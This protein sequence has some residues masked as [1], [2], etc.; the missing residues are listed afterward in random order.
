MNKSKE[1]KPYGHNDLGKKEEVALM[2]DNISHHYDFLNHLLSFGIDRMWRKKAVALLEQDKPQH[3][4]DVA[5]GTGD[6]AIESLSLNPQK[7]IGVDI[8]SKML[9]VGRKKIEKNGWQQ[10]VELIQGDSENLSFE[11]EKF[12]A[13]TV[14]FGVRNFENLDKGLSEMHR[15]LT[16][17]GKLIVL[18]F[19]KPNIFPIKQIYNFYFS[20]ILPKI[21]SVISKDKRA[22]RYLQESVEAFPEGN[23][24]LE[25]MKTAGFKETKQIKLMT[26]VASIYIGNK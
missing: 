11:D 15:V 17:P 10:M 16:R 24:F 6:F 5:T 8:S 13:I 26:G 20:R 22:Y 25:R 21:G 23:A 4:L 3:I 14:G 12:N 18:E 1:I 19:S 9:D 7:I 2:F